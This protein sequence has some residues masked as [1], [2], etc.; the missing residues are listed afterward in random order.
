MAKYRVVG[1][2]VFVVGV[3]ILLVS[4]LADVLGLGASAAVFGYRQIVGSLVGAVIVVAGA[5]LYWRAGGRAQ[6]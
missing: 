1:A 6:R 5:A 3:L 2:V 4:A